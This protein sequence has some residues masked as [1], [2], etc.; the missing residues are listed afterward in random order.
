M[1]V[2]HSQHLASGS[3]SSPP[4]LVERSAWAVTAAFSSCGILSTRSKKWAP[5]HCAG[6]L[7]CISDAKFLIITD[8]RGSASN[9]AHAKERARSGRPKRR[10]VSI[11]ELR[12]HEVEFCLD[13]PIARWLFLSIPV[14]K[15]APSPLEF[16][17][18][19][20][21]RDAQN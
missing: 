14:R 21:G 20:D 5:A 3:A 19:L 6:A 13:Q 1:S 16:S 10:L 7:S 18:T 4:T 9:Q 15:F 17:P 8:W 2:C 11:E 12:S